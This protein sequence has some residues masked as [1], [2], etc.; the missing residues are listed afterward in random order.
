MTISLLDGVTVLDVGRLMPSAI[1]TFELA[2]VGADVIKVEFPPEGD[3][4]RTNP[5]LIAGRGD[6]HLDLN[7]NKRS[8]CLDP[9]TDTGREAL[10][11]LIR[12]ADVLVV[13]ARPQ[14]LRRLG[15]DDVSCR[16]I[17]PG[18]IHCTISGYGTDGPYSGLGAHGLSSDAA[19]GIVP[20]VAGP[21]GRAVVA[22]DYISVGPRAAGLHASLAIVAALYHRDR[23]GGAG[24]SIDVSQWDCAMAWNY[25]NIDQYVNTHERIPAYRELGFRYSIYTTRDDRQVLFAAPE[26]KLWKRFCHSVG[27]PDLAALSTDAVIEFDD[28]VGGQVELQ[29]IFRSRDQADWI[30]LAIR[31]GV[32]IA[33]VLS[34]EEI[35]GDLHVAHREMLVAGEHPLGGT[36]R[37][38]GHP[39]KYGD[40]HVSWRPAPELGGQTSEVLGELGFS[41]SRISLITPESS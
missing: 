22:S 27:R 35:P 41:A 9:S 5:P 29:A 8:I 19:A 18:L 26:P 32:P 40:D 14:S 15:L 20:L 13:A 31:E 1:A 2:K 17:N 6:M 34:L 33:P 36:V 7:R 28:H 37:L 11:G 38:T 10:G 3:Y 24:R 39:T 12:R 21:D 30:D 16:S 23:S 25:R 4:L